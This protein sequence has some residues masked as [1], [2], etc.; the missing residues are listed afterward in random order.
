MEPEIA[1]PYQVQKMPTISIKSAK[2]LEIQRACVIN[3][4]PITERRNIKEKSENKNTKL[5]EFVY[6]EPKKVQ[7]D[8]FLTSTSAPGG[9]LETGESKIVKSRSTFKVKQHLRP[10]KSKN[11]F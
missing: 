8:Q 5:L 1:S 2:P 6:E 9:I 10:G 7:V 11:M 4:E 3:I